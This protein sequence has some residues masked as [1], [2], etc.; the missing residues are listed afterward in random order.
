M[1]KKQMLKGSIRKKT[2]KSRQLLDRLHGSV[3]DAK[4]LHDLR[5]QNKKLKAV[6]Q[7]LKQVSGNPHFTAKTLKP[8]FRLAGQIRTAQLILQQLE[9]YHLEQE[10]WVQEQHASIQQ[11]S[12]K[13]VRQRKHF[14]KAI[15]KLE[16]RLLP[17]CHS[18][19]D[20]KVERYYGQNISRLSMAF[21]LPLDGDQLH[22]NRKDIKS[23]LYA[24]PVLPHALQSRLQINKSYLDE[25]QELIGQWHDHMVLL[26]LLLQKKAKEECLKQL[27]KDGE[28]LL[29]QIEFRTRFLDQKVKL[30]RPAD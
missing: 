19:A 1:V 2:H 3:L 15:A 17:A 8:L 26:E 25:L 11:A 27:Y 20:K 23:L 22:E 10:D 18:V 13:L 9:H 12:E 29:R 6:L 24:L 5:L 30:A 4:T 21:A 16:Q 7:L 14:K 28:E